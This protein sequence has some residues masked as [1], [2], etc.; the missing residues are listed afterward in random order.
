[1]NLPGGISRVGILNA[2]EWSI[3]NCKRTTPKAAF[4]KPPICWSLQ[5]NHSQYL[6]TV[7]IPVVPHKAVAEVSKIGHY[8]R[9]ELL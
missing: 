4:E 2:P 5:L 8:R 3:N 1:M 7:I 6:I 9:G